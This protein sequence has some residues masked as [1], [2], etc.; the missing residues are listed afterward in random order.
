M[1]FA[2]YVF[3]K[4]ALEYPSYYIRVIRANSMYCTKSNRAKLAYFHLGMPLTTAKT[5]IEA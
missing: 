2:A 4:S 1:I 3:L 5:Y